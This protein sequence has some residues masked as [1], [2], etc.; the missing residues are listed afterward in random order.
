GAQSRASVILPLGT[1]KRV[2]A[3][4]IRIC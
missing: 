4:G 3:C 2:Y 1:M